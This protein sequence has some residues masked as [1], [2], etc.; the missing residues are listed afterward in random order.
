MIPYGELKEVFDIHKAGQTKFTR[1]MAIN[2]ADWFNIPVRDMVRLLERDGLVKDGT[3][4]WFVV[5]GGIT[6][7]NIKQVRGERE[8]APS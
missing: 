1:R 8:G 6:K 4:D 3:W 5:N 7:A 2:M